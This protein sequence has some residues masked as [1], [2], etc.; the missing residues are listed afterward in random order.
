MAGLRQDLG[1]QELVEQLADGGL[2][3]GE[4]DCGVTSAQWLGER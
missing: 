3:N 4:K 2:F 1:Q